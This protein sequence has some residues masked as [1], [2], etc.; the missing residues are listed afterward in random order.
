VI[1]HL[2]GFLGREIQILG[3]KCFLTSMRS[4]FGLKICWRLVEDRFRG[5]TVKYHVTY[6]LLVL[7][8]WEIQILGLKYFLTSKSVGGWLMKDLEA[9]RQNMM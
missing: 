6:C 5:C 1:Y 4:H 9:V 3:L 8:G 2:W 7:L